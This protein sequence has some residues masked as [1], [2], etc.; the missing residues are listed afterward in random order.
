MKGLDLKC[1]TACN[2]IWKWL[3]FAGDN[4]E[5]TFITLF[6]QNFHYNFSHQDCWWS[7]TVATV[8]LVRKMQFILQMS[9]DAT[10]RH[11]HASG[12]LKKGQQPCKNIRVTG[13][14][15]IFTYSLRIRIK[16]SLNFVNFFLRFLIFHQFF[17][18][19][20]SWRFLDLS[21][22]CPLK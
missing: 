15:Q 17:L 10:T 1:I 14:L 7:T 3:W 11:S 22:N 4:L 5:K 13:I 6:F 20:Y 21:K 8:L 9:A 12:L 19:Y 2:L 18:F 16:K